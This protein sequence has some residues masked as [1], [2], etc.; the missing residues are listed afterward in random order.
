MLNKFLKILEDGYLVSF[1]TN[2]VDGATRICVAKNDAMSQHFVNLNHA[3]DFGLPKDIVIM[4][5][6]EKLMR[7]MEV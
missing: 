1:D 5:T 3:E 2:R 4:A 7:D 6:I